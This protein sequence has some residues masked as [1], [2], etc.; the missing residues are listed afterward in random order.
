MPSLEARSKAFWKFRW[1]VQVPCI[2]CV[3][4]PFLGCCEWGGEHTSD[5]KRPPG[6]AWTRDAAFR[7]A[8][9]MFPVSRLGTVRIAVPDVVRGRAGR[10]LLWLRV[11][12][13]PGVTLWPRS[14]CGL[15]EV[16]FFFFHN[17]RFCYRPSKT[18]PS[19]TLARPPIIMRFCQNDTVHLTA[20]RVFTRLLALLPLHRELLFTLAQRVL[21]WLSP[22]KP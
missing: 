3:A 21:Y 10:V 17:V 16:P 19:S 7:T 4:L 22:Q 2:G 5:T 11:T 1:D 6:E 18:I 15:V 12:L 9:P 20:H 8:T 13:Q 14:R